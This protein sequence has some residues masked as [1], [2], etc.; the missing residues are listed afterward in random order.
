MPTLFR[1]IIICATI[2]GLVYGGMWALVLMVEKLG[3]VDSELPEMFRDRLHLGDIRELLVLASSRNPDESDK[4]RW[5]CAILR[6]MH[7]FVH[8][9]NDLFSSF[10]E[11]IQAQIL[12]PFQQSI[13]HDGNAHQTF[14]QS[15]D[16]F[17]F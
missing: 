3:F 4:Q 9:E 17:H 10:S 13:R 12:T 1:F 15:A 7:V 5:A 14:L 16:G 2:A 11:E 6:C 8:A